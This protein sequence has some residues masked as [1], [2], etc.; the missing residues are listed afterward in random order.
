VGD[1]SDVMREFEGFYDHWYGRAL[2][3]GP[4]ILL[5]VAGALAVSS[6]VLSVLQGQGYIAYQPFYAV[7]PM[8]IAA[9]SGAYLWATNDL[10]ARARRLDL[11]PSDVLWAALRIVIAVPL[12]YALGKVVNDANDGAFIAF[13]LGAFPLTEIL[14]ILQKVGYKALK[15]EPTKEEVQKSVLALQGVDRDIVERL[16]NEDISTITQ[17]AYCD[18][19][20]LT[21]KSNL[22]F[23]FISDCMSQALAWMYFEDKLAL[24]RR[25]GIRGAVEVKC[26]V[27]D[28]DSD[29]DDS[30]SVQ[31]KAVAAATVK[32]IAAL[33]N[34]DEA[35]VQF[36]LRQISEDPYTVFLAQVWT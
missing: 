26:L 8:A 13:A 24:L 10:I 28:L 6:V 36:V 21:M 15:L 2:Y 16:A 9:L 30:K 4:G 35:A 19:V 23:N 25:F 11:A 5:L 29:K 1:G 32:S 22:G 34:Q 20:R 17:F 14:A 7:P 33:L 27:D 12:G 18:P 3:A 31:A